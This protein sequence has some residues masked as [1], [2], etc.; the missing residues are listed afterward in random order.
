MRL[1][2]EGRRDAMLEALERWAARGCVAGDGAAGLYELVELPAGVDEAALIAA[3]AERG[4]GVEGVS[5]APLHRRRPA[6]ASSS[7]SATSRSRR[8]STGSGSWARLFRPGVR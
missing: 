6:G 8:S 1:R 3:A 5:P 7:A 2:Y 4:V